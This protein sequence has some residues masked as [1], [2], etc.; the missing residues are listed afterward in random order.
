MP[1]KKFTY[2]IHH[3]SDLGLS[4]PKYDFTQ[5]PYRDISHPSP[6]YIQAIRFSDWSIEGWL[7]GKPEFYVT[8][9]NVN[10]S[11]GKTFPIQE[12][13]FLEFRSRTSTYKFPDILVFNWDPGLWYD[14]I[15]FSVVEQDAGGSM[16]IHFSAGFNSKDIKKM[17]LTPV[18]LGLDYKYQVGNGSEQCGNAFLNYFDLPDCWLHFPNYGVQLLVSEKKFAEIVK[19]DLI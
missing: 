8:V 1:G 11:T 10:L 6:V 17:N 14:M 13:I 4:N 18:S 19:T 16:D 2:K 3:K 9:G 5:V 7:A 15:T 12:K